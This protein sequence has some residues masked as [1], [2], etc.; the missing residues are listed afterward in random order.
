METARLRNQDRDEVIR[1][2]FSRL[3]R[4][5]WRPRDLATKVETAQ[6][7]SP[8]SPGLIA[9]SATVVDTARFL[10]PGWGRRDFPVKLE[11][12]LTKVDLK[13]TFATEVETVFYRDHGRDGAGFASKVDTAQL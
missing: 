3:S 7:R 1:K 13:K 12:A 11:T 5:W 2:K 9:F 8:S 4:T 10:Q 6:P